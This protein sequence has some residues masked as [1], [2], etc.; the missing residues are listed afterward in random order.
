MKKLHR[1]FAKHEE[2]CQKEKEEERVESQRSMVEWRAKAVEQIS[3][4]F[5]ERTTQELEK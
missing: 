2:V 4:E 5:Q 1:Y 3:K